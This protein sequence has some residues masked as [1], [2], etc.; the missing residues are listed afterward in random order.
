[1]SFAIIFKAKSALLKNY[2]NCLFNGGGEHVIRWILWHLTHATNPK[3]YQK[4]IQ[5]IITKTQEL[6]DI[7][8]INFLSLVQ[9][10]WLLFPCTITQHIKIK[11]KK[12]VS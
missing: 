4:E 8:P 12:I 5:T 2:L 6:K 11:T 7:H 10:G 9:S 3:I 1:M